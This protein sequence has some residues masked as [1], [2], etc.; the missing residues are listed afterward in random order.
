MASG[1]TN[2]LNKALPYVVGSKTTAPIPLNVKLML[3]ADFK[4]T[5]FKTTAIAAAG[6]L[7]GMT[8]SAYIRSR[9]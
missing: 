5:I 6:L 3:D 8:I 2:I 9:K 7:L 4:K 1:L